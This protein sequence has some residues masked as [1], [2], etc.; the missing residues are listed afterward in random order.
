MKRFYKLVSKSKTDNGWSVELD[1]RPVKTPIKAAMLM[2]T[3]ALA[4]AIMAEWSAQEEVINPEAMPLT[5]LLSTQ[6]DRVQNQR[7]ALR[8]EVLKFLDT[9]LICYRAEMDED[10]PESVREQAKRQALVWDEWTKWFAEKFG[11]ELKTTT[12]IIALRQDEAA[13][14]KTA[15]FVDGL[16][17]AHFTVLQMSVP[18][19]GSIVLAMAFVDGAISAEDLLAAARVEEHFKDEIYNA[20][21]YGRDPMLEEKD[22]TILRDLKAA[23]EYLK[24]L[25]A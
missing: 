2:P 25:K 5:Q 19:A 6:I 20:E 1:G 23:E 17:D 11:I 3:E 10:A 18:L 16:D 13:H 4:D 14:E 15:E 8:G 22:Q 7:D 12:H 21:F 9:D 24:L